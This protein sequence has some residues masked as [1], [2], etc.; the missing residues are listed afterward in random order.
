[1]NCILMNN[2]FDVIN[3]EI[4]YQYLIFCNANN[5]QESKTNRVSSR[6]NIEKK[7]MKSSIDLNFL[8]TCTM[9]KFKNKR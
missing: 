8:F 7:L 2:V 6:S 5:T 4:K 3:F 9:G 1:M